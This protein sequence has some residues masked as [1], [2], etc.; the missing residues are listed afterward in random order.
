VT[1]SK[2]EGAV[3]TATAEGGASGSTPGTDK[4]AA[5]G[6]LTLEESDESEDDD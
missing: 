2:E 3:A 6:G 5:V 4:P 1:H